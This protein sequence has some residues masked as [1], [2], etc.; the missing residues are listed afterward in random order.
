MYL[1]T[2]GLQD[3]ERS[4][5]IIANQIVNSLQ[6][7]G[8]DIYID[9]ESNIYETIEDLNNTVVDLEREKRTAIIF[10]K[11]NVYNSVTQGWQTIGDINRQKST[12]EYKKQLLNMVLKLSEAAQINDNDKITSTLSSI[13]VNRELQ[14]DDRYELLKIVH[15]LISEH[16]VDMSMVDVLHFIQDGIEIEEE[17]QDIQRYIDRSERY[18]L[19]KIAAIIDQ[20]NTNIMNHED[21]DLFVEK[22]IERLLYK[23]VKAAFV[24]DIEDAIYGLAGSIGIDKEIVYQ[25]IREVAE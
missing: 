20:S 17:R 5:S 4:V 24:D 19:G 12:V 9:S 13:I 16:D 1:G 3:Y 14:Q 7:N 2:D 8:V 23:Y 22:I 6:Q 15:S 21:W 11:M 18:V 10:G 25:L